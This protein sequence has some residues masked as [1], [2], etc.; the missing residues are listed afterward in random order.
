MS[1]F[2]LDSAVLVLNRF[3]QAVQVTTVRRAFTLFC[4]DLVKAVDEDY[5]TYT[6]NDWKDLPPD[7]DV[8]HTPRFALQVPRVVQLVYYDKVP[9]FRARFSRKNIFL[10][11]R[12]QCQYCGEPFDSKDLSLDHVVPISRGG[13]HSWDNVV[14]CCVDCNKKKGNRVPKEAGMKLIRLPRRPTWIPFSRLIRKNAFHPS[15]KNFV[16]FAYWN[17]PLY[18]DPE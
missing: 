15:W 12:N 14:C 13:R 18:E 16:D 1:T 4:K 8:I 2:V 7:G 11:D 6:F 17:V 5:L 9:R 10:R 3:F